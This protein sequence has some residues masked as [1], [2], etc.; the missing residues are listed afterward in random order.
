M[1]INELKE[2]LALENVR[3]D[4]VHFGGDLPVRSDQ[5]AITNDREI[6]QVYYFERGE[7][8]GERWFA[9]EAA[10]CDYLWDQ[11]RRDPTTRLGTSGC[12]S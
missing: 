3:P 9:D 4:V 8:Y 7:K 11:I 12:A 5:W 10:A 1:N 2:A 6:W